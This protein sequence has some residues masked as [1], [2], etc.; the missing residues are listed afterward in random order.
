MLNKV[1][2]VRLF[3]LLLQKFSL[4]LL[5]IHGLCLAEE[6][7]EILLVLLGKYLE[8]GIIFLLKYTNLLLDVEDFIYFINFGVIEL[9]V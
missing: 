2:L 1:V 3:L 7:S 4:L 6:L 8:D 9:V 5:L